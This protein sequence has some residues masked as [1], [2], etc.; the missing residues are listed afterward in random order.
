MLRL[1]FVTLIQFLFNIV[2][3]S[4]NHETESVGTKT[5]SDNKTL[6]SGFYKRYVIS[7]ALL[8]ALSFCHLYYYFDTTVTLLDYLLLIGITAF[9]VL[10][11][12]SYYTLNKFFTFKL[13]IKTDHKL[14][15]SGPYQY[16][17]HPS[18]T[19]QIGQLLLVLLFFRMYYVLI[20][21]VMYIMY[22]LPS[23]ISDEEKMMKDHF[24][25]EY[26]EYVQERYRMIPFI[27]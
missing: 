18:Y 21:I 9:T 16:L 12:W 1:L 17:V 19:G 2:N 13:Q 8:Y 15:T 25:T 3:I 24:G 11:L 26:D 10:R 14:I 7:H 22:K 6:N 20:P 5:Y 4:P 23:R 27:Y